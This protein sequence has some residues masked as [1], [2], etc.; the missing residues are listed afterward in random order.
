M[1]SSTISLVGDGDGV[2]VGIAVASSGEEIGGEE[3]KIVSSGAGERGPH[4][5]RMVKENE[6]NKIK[7]KTFFIIP[8]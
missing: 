1:G 3:R 2:K 4:P 8:P 7:T 6:N 5:H